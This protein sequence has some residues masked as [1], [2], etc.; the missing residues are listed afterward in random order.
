MTA[1]ATR[2]G[3]PP[4]PAWSMSTVA[5]SAYGDLGAL[6]FPDAENGFALAALVEAWS[7]VLGWVDDA[8]RPEPG[9]GDPAWAQVLDPF[10]CPWWALRWCGQVYG[11]RLKPELGAFE[12]PAP[13]LEAAWRAEIADRPAWRRGTPGSIVATA[14]LFMTGDRRV[15]LRERYDISNPSADSPY[16]LQVRVRAAD[17]LPGQEAALEAAVRR[18]KP[19]GLVM[20]FEI[21]DDRDWQNVDDQYGS[22]TAVET[23][24]ADWADVLTP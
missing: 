13:A 7:T 22:W 15:T 14:R 4:V 20:H 5:A 11:V 3:S 17:V 21:T 8:A 19:A 10:R 16:H 6:T 24:N 12:R 1:L 18:Q 2:P 23:D 9:T